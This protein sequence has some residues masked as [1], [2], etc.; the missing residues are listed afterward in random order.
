[1][2]HAIDRRAVL[3]GTLAAALSP[4][5]ARAQGAGAFAAME[6]PIAERV[7]KLNGSGLLAVAQ[8][9]RLVHLAGFG[10]MQPGDRY[11]VFSLSKS[12]TGLALLT[13]AQAG[14]LDLDAPIAKYIGPLLQKF[15]PP[16]D[17]RVANVTVRQV[18]THMAGFATNERD[19]DPV[20][21]NG[22]GGFK[23]PKGRERDMPSWRKEDLLPVILKRKLEAEPGSKYV[24]SN[25]GYAVLGLVIEAASGMSYDDYCREFV[26]K[27][28]GLPRPTIE[29]DRRYVDSIS[30][31]QMTAPEVLKLFWLFEPED[32][33]VLN[34]AMHKVALDPS[35]AFINEQRQT[36]YTSGLMVREFR[37]GVLLWYHVGRNQYGAKD[38]QV[39][40]FATR[41][42]SVSVVWAIRPSIDLQDVLAIDREVWTA[43]RAMKD[44]PAHDLFPQHGF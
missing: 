31:W 3:G 42:P 13:L 20:I 35:G 34:A 26:L 9:K 1:M 14:K 6:K 44:W 40:T 41:A 32:T 28:G 16:A 24:Y 15:G 27:P 21:L 30:G 33:R 36:Y 4:A 7:A 18:M 23:P 2:S 11:R 39:F 37:P 43:V 38:Q 8:Q 10:G 19:D 17:P 5:L 12:V 22:A 29:R 25:A